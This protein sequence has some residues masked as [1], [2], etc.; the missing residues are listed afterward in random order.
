MALPPT[1]DPETGTLGRVGNTV[2]RIT[3]TPIRTASSSSYTSYHYSGWER[4]SDGVSGIG[5]WIQEKGAAILAGIVAGL[6][7]LIGFI[8]LIVWVIKV[9][10]DEGFFL[11][12]LAIGGGVLAVG[13]G[14]YA[15][16]L[17]YG[18]AYF[19]I[20]IFGYIFYNA[21][22][23]LIALA[24]GVAIA[25]GSIVN[26]CTPSNTILNTPSTT[27]SA[28]AYTIYHC[29]A[30]VLNVRAE[31]STN[32]KV[33]GTISRGSS[34]MVYGFEGDFARIKWN[35]QTAYVSKHYISE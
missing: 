12:V 32:S 14:Y 1:F 22:T 16:C 33:L 34:V 20:F 11:G 4:F 19:A 26:N 31:P 24:V 21:Y 13:A 2:R 23:L 25:I 15:V 30:K 17:I 29:T 7:A 27:T 5:E 10:I 8:Y 35:G 9:F 6:P 28:P 18:I 3:P